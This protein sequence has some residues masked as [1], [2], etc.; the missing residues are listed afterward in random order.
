MLDSFRSRLVI[1]NL[2]ITLLGL[3]VIVAVFFNVLANR[4]QDVKRNALTTDSRLVANQ[5]EDYFQSRAGAELTVQQLVNQ[6]S[7]ALRVRVIVVR[8]GTNKII[9][10]S[11][12]RTPFFNGSWTLDRRAL[13]R[14]QT[15]TGVARDG[16]VQTFQTP[17]EGT[18]G[19]IIGAVVL[20]A[21]VSDVR[22]SL[23]D[24][25]DL[26]LI[27]LGTAALVWLAIGLFFTFSISRPLLR[28]IHATQRMARG[29]YD[30]RVPP[31]G[32]GEIARLASS[33]NV[34]A[35]Q[36]QGSNRTLK[37]FVANVSH[38]LR[39]PLTMITGFSTALIDGTARPEEVEEAATVIHDEAVK[40]Q[41]MVDDL[42]Q[43]TRLE[44]GLFSFR[45]QPVEVQLFVQSVI[46]RVARTH[47]GTAVA[48][49][50]NQAPAG[51]PPI[52]VAHA[53]FE[54]ALRKSLE[55]ALQ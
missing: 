9:A 3:L 22:P 44:S 28:V 47:S 8:R 1:S 23:G 12:R 32:N 51:V 31:G 4:S 40:M 35:H 43:L 29:Q 42:L 52:A 10:D 21:N 45:R 14:A 5:L 6:T 48:Q 19:H 30:A 20:V 24:F 11:S 50:L 46:E 7:R 13:D 2:L 54:R 41:H 15:A 53:H 18:R 34:M 38:D 39:T 27:V 17:L 55:N 49:I 33:F 36:V 16:K 26:F 25:R 37:D